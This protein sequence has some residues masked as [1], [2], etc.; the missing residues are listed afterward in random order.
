MKTN[1]VDKGIP[2]IL[3][4]YSP[5]HRKDLPSD[6]NE[7]HQ[8]SRVYYIEYLT[9][10]AIKNGLVP[11]YWD[12]GYA[13]NNGSAIFDRN[14]GKIVDQGALDAIMKAKGEN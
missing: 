3:G 2:V 7:L 13:G 4:E 11:I 9:R 5:L 6:K 1:F 12:N 10:E 8:A 14:N